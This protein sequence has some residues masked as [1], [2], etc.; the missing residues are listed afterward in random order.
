MKEKGRFDDVAAT[1]LPFRRDEEQ[2]QDLFVNDAVGEGDGQGTL[3][4]VADSGN[5]GIPHPV[6]DGSKSE[7]RP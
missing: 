6:L 4:A 3:A 5:G 7:K 1:E 2:A